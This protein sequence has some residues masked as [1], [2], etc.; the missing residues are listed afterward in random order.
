MCRGWP[1]HEDILRLSGGQAGPAVS[2]GDGHQ[3]HEGKLRE[4]LCRHLQRARH[5]RLERQLHGAQEPQDPAGQV[6]HCRQGDCSGWDLSRLSPASLTLAGCTAKFKKDFCS[7]FL[8]RTRCSVL[9][10]KL[11]C[12][13]L[14]W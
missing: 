10:T 4:V 5:H 3:G 6:R 9:L 14:Y 7:N 12:I 8:R 13:S 2:P 1:G 11:P